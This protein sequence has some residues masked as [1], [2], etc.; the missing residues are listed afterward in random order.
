MR[1]TIRQHHHAFIADVAAQMGCSTTTALDYLL[2]ELRRQG[3]T[4]TTPTPPTAP[5]KPLT[6]P[7]LASIQSGSNLGFVGA[8]Q[9][10][11]EIDPCIERLSKLIEEF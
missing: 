8:V 4:F 9:P 11:Q 3:F 5:T 7:T 6:A 10:F 1:L 2:F